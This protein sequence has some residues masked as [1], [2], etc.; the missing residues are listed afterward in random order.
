MTRPQKPADICKLF[1]DMQRSNS[2]KHNLRLPNDRRIDRVPPFSICQ[3][4]TDLFDPSG[5]S[6]SDSIIELAAEGCQLAL[7]A[8]LAVLLILGEIRLPVFIVRIQLE[9]SPQRCNP[10]HKRAAPERQQ[11]VAA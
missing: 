8:N 9:H 2:L 10:L 6:R 4:A 5:D 11:A 3:T 1:P 7:Q